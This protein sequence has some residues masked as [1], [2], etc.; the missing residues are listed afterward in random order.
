MILAKSV[1]RNGILYV[2]PS[3]DSGDVEYALE[4][5]MN[6]KCVIQSQDGQFILDKTQKQ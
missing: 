2:W 5:L 3:P 4:T 6:R 1:G